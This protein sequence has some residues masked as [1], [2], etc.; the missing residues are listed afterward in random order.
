MHL[1]CSGNRSYYF[2]EKTYLSNEVSRIYNLLS[3]MENKK[4]QWKKKFIECENL[5]NRTIDR[6][7]VQLSYWRDKS[8]TDK[9]EREVQTDI[10]MLDYNKIFKN[11]ESVLYYKN[12]NANMLTDCIEKI[13]Y[14]C[15]KAKLIPKDNLLAMIS[16]IYSEKI[17][18]DVKNSG[19]GPNQKVKF[20]DILYNF[21]RERF[22][23]H[24]ITK[25]HCEEIIFSTLK[26]RG[27]DMY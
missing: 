3:E 8:M 26:Y 22:K 10:D 12:L 24:K 9:I 23:L 5:F 16:D 19:L 17:A 15:S 2:E 18:L 6:Y 1:I 21:M 20:N 14:E 25:I 27:E 7:E 11:H 4:E 13:R